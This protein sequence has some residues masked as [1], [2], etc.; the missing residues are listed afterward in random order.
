MGERISNSPEVRERSVRMVQDRA[1]MVDEGRRIGEVG[2]K[3][4]ERGIKIEKGPSDALGFIE[5]IPVYIE[6]AVDE[7]YRREGL[8]SAPPACSS[9]LAA[10]L[11]AEGR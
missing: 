4:K 6:E 3:V 11:G 5:A 7:S 8:A 1:A 9:L 2:E 10:G